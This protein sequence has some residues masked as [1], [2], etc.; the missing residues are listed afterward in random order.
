MLLIYYRLSRLSILLHLLFLLPR[1]LF[2]QV[3]RYTTTL[4]RILKE[5]ANKRSAGSVSRLERS[6]RIQPSW[7]G[8]SGVL[9]D[10]IHEQVGSI[11]TEKRVDVFICEFFYT[12][13][14]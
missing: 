10:W 12:N 11:E 2:V 7:H 13:R 8:D 5:S 14:V 3:V 6:S 4:G 9:K 1:L